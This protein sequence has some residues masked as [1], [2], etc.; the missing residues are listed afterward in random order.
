AAFR[1]PGWRRSVRPWN[2]SILLACGQDGRV[3][4]ARLAAF[5]PH[6]ERGRPCP[7]AAKMAAFRRPA[8]L[9][10]F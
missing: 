4:L 6:L 3:P 1:W 7:H 10:F 5:R 9:T 2:A 8:G